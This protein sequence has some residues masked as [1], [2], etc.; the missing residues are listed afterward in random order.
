MKKALIIRRYDMEEYPYY[1][2]P[3]KRSITIDSRLFDEFYD[4]NKEIFL[5]VKWNVISVYISKKKM[6]IIL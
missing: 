3:I 5:W 6:S 1:Y 4:A 2:E